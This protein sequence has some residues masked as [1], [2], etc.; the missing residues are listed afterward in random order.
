MAIMNKGQLYWVTGLSGAGKTTISTL[1]YNYLKQKQDNIFLIDGD[2]IREVYQNTDYSEEGREKIS[3]T[4]MRLCK[5]LTDQGIDV[6]I[7]VIGMR[8]VYREWNRANIE[9]YREIYLE[10]PME[11]LIRRDSKG[12]Y[13]KALRKEI[14]DVY[15]IDM[16]YE[17]PKHP[18]V[19]IMNDSS[20]TPEEVCQ[21]IIDQL[22]L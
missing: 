11:E 19:H 8:D 15:G 22:N 10:V 1:L 3:Y 13:S 2:K 12:L 9:N 6:I 18:D 21:M 4:N 17:E 20:H 14:T 5:M 7:A 16:P